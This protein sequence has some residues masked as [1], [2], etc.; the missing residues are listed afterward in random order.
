MPELPEVEAARRLLDAHCTGKTIS[1]PTV[2]NDE[3]VVEGIAP[4][5][6][7]KALAN[8]TVAAA[9]RLG[10]HLWLEFTDGGP[11]LLLHFGMTGAAVVRGKGAAHYQ[12]YSVSDTEWPPKFVK[13]ELD[14]TD[15][16]QMA[17]VDS[18]RFARIR[19]IADPLSVP[20]LST[21]GWDPLLNMP[22]VEDFITAVAGQ[23][24]AI[25][26]LLLDQTFTAGVGNWVAD[27]VLYQSCIHPEQPANTLQPDEVKAL[28]RHIVE[29]C[30]VASDA[31]ADAE[32]LPETWLFHHRWGKGSATKSKVNGQ[33]IDHIT[34]GG[35]TSAY[36]PALQ[37]LKKSAAV[38]GTVVD[39]GK[40]A[41]K[42]EK[43]AASGTVEVPVAPKT[44]QTRGAEGKDGITAEV[45]RAGGTRVVAKVAAPKPVKARSARAQGAKMAV[46][47]AARLRR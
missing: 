24:R 42:G 36:V 44:K 22:S 13:L 23:R 9:R 47:S 31:G 38:V 14:F 18:R 27:E 39:G 3:K 34:V 11:A 46:T 21:L 40:K 1:Q 5:E 15:G 4:A 37:K 41:G 43:R 10:K 17:F 28:H 32:R 8:R 16:T 19:L 35:R 26:A 6:L 45:K 30:Q 12:R 7:S 20:P 29:V 2:A 25:K 33:T